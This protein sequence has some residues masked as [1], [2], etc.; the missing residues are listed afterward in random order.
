MDGVSNTRTSEGTAFQAEK[1]AIPAASEE[2]Q[3]RYANA[4]ACGANP[5][6]RRIAL[7]EPRGSWVAPA[8]D[9]HAANKKMGRTQLLQW[10]PN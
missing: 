5:V 8:S 6:A 2:G 7:I 3:A 10:C 4:A 9:A 1:S